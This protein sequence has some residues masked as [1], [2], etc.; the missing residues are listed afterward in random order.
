[1]QLATRSGILFA[2]RL[3][4]GMFV[5]C[6]VLFTPFVLSFSSSSSPLRIFFPSRWSTLLLQLGAAP[7]RPFVSTGLISFRSL[8]VG[9]RGLSER[10]LPPCGFGQLG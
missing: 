3:L 7:I 6:G 8:T 9:H 4:T 10:R 2:E 5:S 1:M